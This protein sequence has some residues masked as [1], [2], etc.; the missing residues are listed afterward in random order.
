MHKIFLR[1]ILLWGLEG[2]KNFNLGSLS[3]AIPYIFLGMLNKFLL[4]L[5]RNV[6]NTICV[7]V[8]PFQVFSVT[9]W[10]WAILDIGP[11]LLLPKKVSFC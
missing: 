9:V 4:L 5:M 2:C 8:F 11:D 1:V 3:D 7:N 10:S 6:Q